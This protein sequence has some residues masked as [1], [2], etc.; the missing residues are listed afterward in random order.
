MSECIKV[1]LLTD[2]IVL[3]EDGAYGAV[4]EQSIQ[5]EPYIKARQMFV[6]SSDLLARGLNAAAG[7]TPITT[8]EFVTLCTQHNPIQS[9]F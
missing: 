5:L 6:L 9:W 1:A 4:G 7:I 8:A 2:I 3:T